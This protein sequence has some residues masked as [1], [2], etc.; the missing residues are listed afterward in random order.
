MP[1]AP[2]YWD[3]YWARDQPP[4]ELDPLTAT[5][6]ETF[7]RLCPAKARI[8]D[9]GCGAGRATQLLCARDH[10]V[11]ALDIS[12]KALRRA[13]VRAPNADYLEAACDSSLPFADRVF[14]AVYCTEVI[15]HTLDAESMLHESQRILRPEGLLFLTTPYHGLVKNLAIAA[16]SFDRH[17]DPGG[18]HIRFFSLKSLRRMLAKTGF[19]LERIFYWGRFWPVWMNMG[20]Y[21]RK[22]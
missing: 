10:R 18:P 17:F 2:L 1:T 4:P 21:A 11:T 14:D 12:L 20:I 19:R 13:G 15:E 5:R 7:L 6:V 8:L 16:A 9:L 22:M 3:K